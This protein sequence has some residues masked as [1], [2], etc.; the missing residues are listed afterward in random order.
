MSY[1]IAINKAWDELFA[2]KPAKIISVK[3]LADDYTVDLDNK[4]IFSLS[5]NIPAKDYLAILLLHYLSKKL[6][7]LPKLNEEW[8]DFKEISHI[9]GYQSAFKKRVIERIIRK[10]GAA[11]DA[12]LSALERLP[13]KRVDLGD[14]G[15]VLQ[16]CEGVPVVV[17]LWR[18]DEEFGPGANM[19]FDKSITQIFC[20]EDIVV[21][22]ELVVGQL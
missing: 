4:K 13:G 22:S 11:P 14:V 15:I 5:C 7:G 1:D 3:F 12:L 17:Q 9:E 8:L 19:L 18:P 20:V 6:K 2:L 16:I 21:L 10:Y